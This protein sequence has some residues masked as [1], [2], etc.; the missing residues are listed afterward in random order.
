MSESVKALS[1]KWLDCGEWN[2]SALLFALMCPHI[3]DDDF[4][5]FLKTFTFNLSGT[6]KSKE[7]GGTKT[8]YNEVKQR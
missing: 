1:H 8:K 4:F 2:G 3:F 5:Q 7:A 6:K